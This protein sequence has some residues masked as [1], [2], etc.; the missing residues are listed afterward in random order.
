VSHWDPSGG[1][2]IALVCPKCGR[3]ISHSCQVPPPSPCHAFR[4]GDRVVVTYPPAD[5]I[6]AGSF[7]GCVVRSTG[8]V[9]R[10]TLEYDDSTNE[11]VHVARKASGSWVDLDYGVPCEVA[12]DG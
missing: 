2:A 1:P 8:H 10:V 11:T 3:H 6:E 4:R 7:V 5:G 9:V 12:S